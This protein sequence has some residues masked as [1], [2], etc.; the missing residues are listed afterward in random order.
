MFRR[1]ATAGL[2]KGTEKETC[3]EQTYIDAALVLKRRAMCRLDNAKENVSQ[4]Y[5]LCS[6]TVLIIFKTHI[7]VHL[8]GSYKVINVI[9]IEVK[10]GKE[11][12]SSLGSSLCWHSN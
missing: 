9:R 6:P 2:C 3:V 10:L 8:S 11:R 5:A 4:K 12:Y 1:H 7:N